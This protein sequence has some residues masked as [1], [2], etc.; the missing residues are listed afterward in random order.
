MYI[1][2]LFL[3]KTE[4]FAKKCTVQYLDVIFSYSL[5]IVALK[6][7]FYFFVEKF[8][9]RPNCVSKNYISS[10]S[11]HSFTQNLFECCKNKVVTKQDIHFHLI[12][13]G[14]LSYKYVCTSI[15]RIR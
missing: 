15:V 13:N 11:S 12:E 1:E 6:Y 9:C 8:F 7:I 5:Y 3:S 2:L 14:Q 10:S 4:N